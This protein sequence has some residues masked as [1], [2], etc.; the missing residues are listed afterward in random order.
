MLNLYRRLGV[1][2]VWGRAEFA[3]TEVPRRSSVGAPIVGSHRARRAWLAG[4]FDLDLVGLVELISVI[5]L[6]DFIGLS[7][8]NLIG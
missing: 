8:F 2:E 6:F 3:M 7:D 1:T 4:L 5:G